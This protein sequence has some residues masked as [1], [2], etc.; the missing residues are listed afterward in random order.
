MT[1]V[2]D[3]KY[4]FSV[5]L[6]A[7]DYEYKAA[8]DNWSMQW[9][10]NG[11]QSIHLDAKSVVTFTLD[12][13]N[14]TL[15]ANAVEAEESFTVIFKDYDGTT[16]STQTVAKGAAAVAPEAPARDGY[17]FTG[18]DKS[19]DNITADTTVT[20]QYEKKAEETPTGKLKIE[21]AGGVS[22]KLSVDGGTARPQGASYLN[23][24]M[25]VNTTITVTAVETSYSEFL[26][27]INTA[28]GKVLTTDLTYTFVTSGNDFIK[29]MFKTD[30]EGVN[31]VM[32]YSDK[33]LQHWDVQYYSADDEIIFPDLPMAPGY[34]CTGWNMTAEEIKAELLKGNDVT[35]T[36]VWVRQLVYVSVTV[37]GGSVTSYVEMNG[38]K[39]LANSKVTVTA[40]AA[41]SGQKFAYW[42]DA[43]GKVKSYSTSYTFYPQADTALTAVFVGE[44][45]TV[46]YKVL[47]SVDAYADAGQYGQ[48]TVTWYVPEDALG[49]EYIE[50]GIV[51]VNK[52]YYNDSAFFHGTTDTNVYDRKGNEGTKPANT[53][54]WT[55]PIYSGETW[56][57]KAFVKYTD[58][59]GETITLYSDLYEITKD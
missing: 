46:D 4:T 44:S 3:N 9:P 53:Y 51:A 32:F 20:A 25:P 48:F 10:L 29:A 26:G 38:D 16:L 39:Y 8:N 41:A 11:N 50:G 15:V 5:T 21:V 23:T 36:P 49:L 59:S 31:M 27:W 14:H 54:V 35:V 33:T 42:V 45:E 28:N 56:V 13:A 43:N 22:F 47:V 6:E 19:F 12:T 18:W 55:G 58:A 30:V 7:G 57:A 24:K 34:D 1:K 52:A 40:N 17:T 2:E 37:D